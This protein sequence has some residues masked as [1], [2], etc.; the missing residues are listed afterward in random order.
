M[1]YT[2][3]VPFRLRISKSFPFKEGRILSGECLSL[4]LDFKALLPLHSSLGLTIHLARTHF[5]GLHAACVKMNLVSKEKEV[6]DVRD[7]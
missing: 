5:V 3:G 4:N 1:N 6:M 7:I 2:L